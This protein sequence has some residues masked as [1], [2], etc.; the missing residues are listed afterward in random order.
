MRY[1]L[2]R[3][4]AGKECHRPQTNGK[5][6]RYHQTVKGIVKQ[7]PYEMPSDLE[8]AL[9]SFIAYYNYGRYHNALGNVTPSDVINGGRAQ[10]LLRRKEIQTRTI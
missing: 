9:V 3:M 7:V 8:A 4:G 2:M 5:L 1:P 6:E 10:I